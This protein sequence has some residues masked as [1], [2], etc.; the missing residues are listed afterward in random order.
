MNHEIVKQNE[1]SYLNVL[2]YV[3]QQGIP[4]DDRTNTGTLSVFGDCN[5]KFQLMAGNERILP[6]LSTKKV[7]FHAIMHELLW[8]LSGSSRL[9]YLKDNGVNIWDEWVLPGTEITDPMTHEE[10]LAYCRR[11]FPNDYA[12][13]ENVVQL[14]KEDG[15]SYSLILRTQEAHMDRVGVPSEKLLDG[16]LGPVYGAQWRNFEDTRFI[17]AKQWLDDIEGW[18]T[19]GFKQLGMVRNDI[20]LT[21][22]RKIDQIAELEEAVRR[23]SCSRRMIVSAWNPARTDEM[24]LPPCHTLAQWSIKKTDAGHVLDCKLYMRSADLLIGVPFNIVFYSLMTHMLAHT[25][26]LIAGTQYVTFGDAHI[27][28]NH[29][30]QVDLQLSRNIKESNLPRV[31][32]SNDKLSILDYTAS[33]I[34]LVGYEHDAFISAPVAV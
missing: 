12:D 4:S 26:G 28:Q 13:I 18:E 19:R 30:N 15:R 24:A 10:R 31:I 5:M 14:M 16:D 21:I 2:S 8:M 6:L 3:R 17:T 20:N 11:K 1:L 23:K 7:N 25:Y 33:D 27:Y 29:L 34:E 9:K 22:Q 32:L